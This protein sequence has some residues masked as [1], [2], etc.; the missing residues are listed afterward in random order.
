MRKVGVFVLVLAALSGAV[1]AWTSPERPSREVQ[2]ASSEDASV[3]MPVGA[4]LIESLANGD[5]SQARSLLAPNIQ[6]KAYTPTKGVFE[7]FGEDA[8]MALYLEWY[9]AESVAEAI[10]TERVVDR[11][12]VGYRIRWKDAENKTFVFQQQ[13]YYDVTDG[14]ITHLQLVCSGDRPLTSR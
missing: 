10:E 5:F 1:V 6:F 13:A 14:L 12:R 8:V 4:R 7:L 11:N 2:L 3:T 9:E